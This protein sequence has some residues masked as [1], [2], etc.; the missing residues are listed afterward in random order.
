MIGKGKY[1]Y[2]NGIIE[3]GGFKEGRLNGFGVLI[4]H[5]GKY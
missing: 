5:D 1:V 4:A 3:E 2:E